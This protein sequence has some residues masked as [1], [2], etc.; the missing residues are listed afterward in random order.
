MN[1]Y[2]RVMNTLQGLPTDRTPV[3]AVLGAYGGKLTGVDLKT[4]Y[5]DADAYVAGQVAAQEKFGFD[6]ALSPFNYSAIAEA[7]GGQEVWFDNQVPNIKRPAV[8]D[9]ASALNIP[10]P[11]PHKSGRLPVLLSATRKLAAIYKGKVPIFAAVPGPVILPSLIM[12][13]EGWMETFLFDEAMAEKLIE[14]ANEFFLAWSNAL[15]KAGADGLYVTEA[16]STA[17]VLPLSLF[18]DRVMPCLNKSFAEVKGPI[19]FP[20]SGGG[21]SHIL[22]LVIKLPGVVGVAI[23]PKEDLAESRRKIG[24]NILLLGNLDDISFAEASSD[25]IYA[26]SI[27]CLKAA[28]PAGHYILAH[29]GADIPLNTPPENL[30]AMIIA[31]KDY[32]AGK[33]ASHE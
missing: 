32:A 26:Q 9:A 25:E 7:F 6:L 19:V 30:M 13:M 27:S 20:N 29:S 28:A 12:G 17:E 31:S 23:S 5:C 16:M 10:M 21:I 24:D 14:Y 4:L 8:R 2:E 22:D 18:A 3:F 11:D 15:L 33:R 1:A